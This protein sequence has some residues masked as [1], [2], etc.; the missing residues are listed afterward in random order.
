[1]ILGLDTEHKKLA[2]IFIVLQADIL[3]MK[4]NCDVVIMMRNRHGDGHTVTVYGTAGAGVAFIGN[5]NDVKIS[6]GGDVALQLFMKF[7]KGALNQHFSIDNIE[8]NQ[9]YILY[10][11]P[12]QTLA[13][14]LLNTYVKLLFYH[15]DIFTG[16]DKKNLQNKKKQNKANWLAALIL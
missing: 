8:A 13:L 6:E 1:M 2:L 16:V 14:Y 3:N 4:H 15:Y 7:M 12:K 11:L 5:R 9:I 10:E